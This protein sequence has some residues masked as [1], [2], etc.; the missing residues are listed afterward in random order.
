M[1]KIIRLS[2]LLGSILIFSACKKTSTT[3]ANFNFE[4]IWSVSYNYTAGSLASG[5]FK[6][7]LK[8]GGNWD[9]VE[10]T[11]SKT[12]AGTWTSSGGDV[13]FIFNVFGLANYKG[14][15]A[16]NNSM[17]GTMVANNGSATG[18]WTANR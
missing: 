14:S 11:Y 17:A 16:G 5:T 4:G 10:G 13:N 6:A 8:A 12:D 9:I 3:P 18:N 1:K 2:L 15:K 7:T